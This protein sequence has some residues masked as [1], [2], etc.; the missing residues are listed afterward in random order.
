[1]DFN[2]ADE[3]A[4][5]GV[6]VIF[7]SITSIDNSFFNQ[8]LKDEIDNYYKLFSQK[9]TLSDFEYD[10]S[11]LAYNKLHTKV[12]VTDKSL[13]A[14]PES[15]IKIL[16]K[17]KSL[18]PIN[19]IVDTYNYISIKNKVSIGAHDMEH[20]N[21]NVELRLTNG[22]EKFIPLGKD[23]PQIIHSGE[24]GYIDDSNEVICRLDCRQCDKTKISSNTKSCLFIIQ[25]NDVTSTKFLHSTAHQLLD[26]FKNNDA[27]NTQY[28]I[29]QA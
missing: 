4:S 24:Y 13:T 6:N 16:L 2:V 18:R 29:I 25:G 19:P 11:I 21:G 12:G 26:L 15:I 3:V 1:M 10:P 27:K 14:S 20:I 9:Y 23:K 22:N 5:L 28:S 8:S 17:H 7:L